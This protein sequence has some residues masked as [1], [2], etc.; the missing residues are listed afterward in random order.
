MAAAASDV[1]VQQWF[2]AYYQGSATDLAVWQSLKELL[3][4][5]RSAA[6]SHS[7]SSQEHF[8]IADIIISNLT[9]TLYRAYPLV[10][11]S[12]AECMMLMLDKAKGP[13]DWW[14][15]CQ[16]IVANV[17]QVIAE[18][19]N[20]IS[21]QAVVDG[22]TIA[23]L[24]TAGRLVCLVL[25]T[26]AGSQPFVSHIGRSFES[27]SYL[28]SI[29]QQFVE[30]LPALLEAVGQLDQPARALSSDLQRLLLQ[31]SR[32]L[33]Q[34][35]IS[36]FNQ[37][38]DTAGHLLSLYRC[39]CGYKDLCSG[40]PVV[41][42]CL[43]KGA[44]SL[45]TAAAASNPSSAK[46]VVD[47]D[48]QSSVRSLLSHLLSCLVQS[49]WAYG[50]SETSAATLINMLAP[51][52]LF[53]SQQTCHLTSKLLQGL[54]LHQDGSPSAQQKLSQLPAQFV[55]APLDALLADLPLAMASNVLKGVDM[56][57]VDIRSCRQAPELSGPTLLLLDSIVVSALQR[58]LAVSRG[59]ANKTADAQ[60]F[61][62]SLGGI[63]AVLPS[64][65]RWK[66]SLEMEKLLADHTLH[67][68][69]PASL[70]LFN[71]LSQNTSNASSNAKPYQSG[72]LA[73]YLQPKAAPSSSSSSAVGRPAKSRPSNGIDD[74][75]SSLEAQEECCLSD[76]DN[77]WGFLGKKRG[78]DVDRPAAPKNT[79]NRFANTDAWQRQLYALRREAEETKRAQVVRRYEDEEQEQEQDLYSE[80]RASTSFLDQDT[81]QPSKKTKGDE[82][83]DT[84]HKHAV[85]FDIH[86]YKVIKPQP[87]AEAAAAEAE[88]N[89][90]LFLQQLDELYRTQINNG[91][92]AALDIDG[93]VNS[94][95]DPICL[96]ILKLNLDEVLQQEE[97][98]AEADRTVRHKAS[99][100]F[101]LPM[102][103]LDENKYIAAY[104]PLL[105]DEFKAALIAFILNINNAD[106]GTSMFAPG[107][108]HRGGNVREFEALEI[109]CDVL[110]KRASE[111]SLQEAAVHLLQE[112]P[113]RAGDLMKDELVLVVKKRLSAGI[114]T[115][116][117]LVRDSHSLGIVL[118]S[119]RDR[120]NDR[121][122]GPTH[123]I[124]IYT[125]KRTVTAVHSEAVWT[126]VPMF[127]LS[128]F[129]REW[130]A[131]LSMK[132]IQSMPLATYLLKGSPVISAA[133]LIDMKT[134]L[135]AKM[136][137]IEA[138][139]KYCAPAH[140]IA[141]LH[142][143]LLSDLQAL[144]SVQINVSVLK[145]TNI[146]KDVKGI[147]KN[148][149]STFDGPCAAVAQ[150][151]VSKWTQAVKVDEATS[152]I[153]N[154]KGG[155]V[156]EVPA[157][158]Q[159]I[160]ADG[161]VPAELW[162]SL[163]VE[164]NH[165]QLFAMH[166]SMHMF[167]SL[168][169]T[170]I[171]LIQG[172]PGT[173]K[174]STIV[175]VLSGL[176][177][178]LQPVQANQPRRVLICAPSNAAIDEIILRLVSKGLVVPGG[179]QQIA[180][181][182][183]G[184]PAPG[185]S[186]NSNLIRSV[187]LEE[188]VE[189]EVRLDAL[190]IQLVNTREAIAST[191]KELDALQAQGKDE[192]K[193]KRTSRA[194]VCKDSLNELRLI[195]N[196]TE[197]ALDKLRIGIRQ[198]ILLNAHVI[199]AT[200]SSSNKQHFLDYIV[201]EQ[202]SFNTVI[203]DEAAQTTE[204]SSLIP[205][206]LGC[207]HLILIGDPRQLPATVLSRNAQ[208]AGLG[209][210]LFER[211]EALEHEVVMLTVQYRMHPQIRQFP[212]DFFYQSLLQDSPFIQKEVAK[213][214]STSFVTCAKLHALRMQPVMFINISGA[215][216]KAGTSFVNETEIS[217]VLAA[218]RLFIQHG[219]HKENS[220]AVIT[221]YKAQVR[222]LQRRLREDSTLGQA[223]GIEVN[224][225]DGF[226]GRERDIIL[227][228]TVRSNEQQGRGSSSH[229][230][231]GFVA[232]ERRLNVAIT[233][234]RKALLIYGNERTLRA[235]S[236]WSELLQSL[237]SRRLVFDHLPS[238]GDSSR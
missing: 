46:I 54:A 157:D 218:L 95:I 69:V 73:G 171:V 126:V 111:P 123:T 83:D 109:K 14:A 12:A 82:D 77:P 224:T 232:D 39:L 135:N 186:F 183:L 221:P 231:I 219:V 64:L 90:S 228:S 70:V 189:K 108:R 1:K 167:R 198:G 237:H 41:V 80:A 97:Q 212:S 19:L 71:S 213:E 122:K 200:L 34:Q 164:Y 201:K 154:R 75:F 21:S 193:G 38:S 206:R 103:F 177:H 190:Y 6:A 147:A 81:F 79:N 92:N 162:D 216:A 8:V 29:H 32:A 208:R 58:A 226:Q 100:E 136:S 235:D 204:V 194:Q 234:A 199:C 160:N 101:A 225:I 106:L 40:F 150:E 161:A 89:K 87:K 158:V 37:D 144:L 98:A 214:A 44:A 210:S 188:Q 118:S 227:F 113:G 125:D 36:C 96:E 192:V 152:V 62:K 233:R 114:T 5:F 2:E 238:S 22:S 55:S 104:Q 132:A 115:R 134:A 102:S 91:I 176:L 149:A 61:A 25:S 27:L 196:R 170:N 129:L 57:L 107:D 56:S 45:L 159:E 86:Q 184:D 76:D 53:G 4:T 48:L 236:A 131:L 35:V 153:R 84:T 112:G 11:L 169:Q 197:Q 137:A 130:H 222:A 139:V 165:S 63:I 195:R 74:L 181:V 52:A 142:A 166:Y 47:R 202:I 93:L 172:P 230:R 65:V 85:L 68:V 141:P 59:H 23:L 128:T 187:V 26:C 67:A 209:R 211:L 148:K 138:A 203:I 43:L 9:S 99:N 24:C 120:G 179:R 17:L 3:R 215:E 127:N 175:G 72:S 168:Q 110:V 229:G 10:W 50:Y 33:R 146:G 163:C 13:V 207:R 66:A 133:Q 31:H 185:N 51:L 124:L 119:R 60:L 88:S 155:K 30:Y 20:T 182:R 16:A 121:T 223:E 49:S 15:R 116:K 140:R 94:S 180:V 156:L 42:L 7:H 105:I 217:K 151:L 173:G 78:H 28:A 117:A 174:T 205:L 18:V 143:A 191:E 220:I 145:Y 178:P